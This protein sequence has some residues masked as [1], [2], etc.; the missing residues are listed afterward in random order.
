MLT[1]L[2]RRIALLASL[3]T[4]GVL[5]AALL[6]SFFIAQKQYE[7][8][9]EAAFSQAV[10]QLQYQWE[11]FD[12]LE[13]SW[14]ARLESQ[15]GLWVQLAENGRPL[16]YSQRQSAEAAAALQAA[17]TMARDSYRADPAVQ[18][19]A[20]VSEQSADFVFCCQGVRYR[21]AVRISGLADGGW[22][23]LTAVQ[24]LAAEGNYQARLAAVFLLVAAG[25]G[26]IL[27]LV[28]WFVAGRAVAPVGHAMDQQ[29]QFLSEAGHE[30]RT[31]LAVIRANVGAAQS[32][33]DKAA[34]Y[35]RAID[36]ESRRMGQL[37]DELLLLSAGA[38][39]R[40]RLRMEPLAP[41]TFLLDFVEGVEPLAAQR[42]KRLETR[43]PASAL[44]LV[45]ADGYRLRQLLGIL[46][47]NALDYAPPDSAVEL[48]LEARGGGVRFVVTDH[49]P[50]VADRDKKRIFERFVRAG[51]PRPEADGRQH[52]GLGLAVAKELASLHR[53]RLWVEDAFG[54]GAAFVLELPAAK[55]R[56]KG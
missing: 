46:L 18:P 56:P 26:G 31:P 13:D 21:C 42:G 24:S 14:L 34:G 8:S 48:T 33:P 2:R 43:L 20:G 50:G 29:Q 52:Y 47:D 54:G 6:F 5:A 15:N 51:Q 37:V 32:R 12:L 53:G 39:A 28:C 44:P 41:D 11:R 10:G 55:S 23:S 35:L 19:L 1:R 30:L 3:L 38:S 9:R 49:G 4:G 40:G 25:C 17:E 27:S 22:R 45:W 7:T 36:G 16:L